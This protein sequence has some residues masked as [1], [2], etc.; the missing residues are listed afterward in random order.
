MSAAVEPA[1]GAL[2]LK[3]DDSPI[4]AARVV[5]EPALEVR[6]ALFAAIPRRHTNRGPYRP[7]QPVA[8]EELRRLAGLASGGNLRLAFVAEEGA[9]RDLGALIVE[10]TGRI[11]GDAEMSADSARW[12][13]TGRRDVEAHRDGVTLDAAGLSPQMTALAK[14]LPDMDAKTSDAY[15]LAMT[16]DVQVPTAPALGIVFVR[17][18]LDMA[19]RDRG[20]A[21]LAA[22]ASRG[23][24]RRTGGA[25]AEPA[26]RTR[27]PRQSAGPA[28][29]FRPRAREIRRRARLGGDLRLPPGRPRTAGAAQPEAGAGGGGKGVGPPGRRPC[30]AILD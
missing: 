5:L 16:R 22:A 6:D 25:A 23:D 28:R 21:G 1:E 9:R 12:F 26:G 15:W 14:L 20:G 18:R 30:P 4:R 2:T 17:D 29:R 19:A 11:V 7:D 10:A 8:P 3:P 24:R 13:R 27:R